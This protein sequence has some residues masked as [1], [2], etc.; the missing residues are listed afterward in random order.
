[1]AAL[2]ADRARSYL[3][4]VLVLVATW[5]IIASTTDTFRGEASVFSVLEGFPL[6]GLVALGLAI[7][8]IAG[9]LDL[10]V[11]SMAALA[12]VVAV[13]TSSV[14]LVGALVIATA[15]GAAIG[16]LQGG[17]IARLGINSLVLTVGTLILL[18]GVTYLAS[19]NRPSQL[20]DFTVSDPL[21][22]RYGIFSASSITALVVFG[23]LGLF[24]AYT[25]Y[26]REIY[27]IGGARDEARAAGVPR[28]RPMVVT[29]ALSGAC[30]ALAGGLASLKGGSAAPQNYADLLLA[31][32]AAALLGG[33]SLYGGRG[34]VL[35]VALGV[36][37]LSAVSAG[38]AARGSDASVTQLVTGALLISVVAIEFTATR[39][40]R[41][42]KL[43][44]EAAEREALPPPVPT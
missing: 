15:M 43:R 4:P 39:L 37:V 17:I 31:G 19:D 1:M 30:A 12:G 8:I 32:A 18:R 10:S 21:L 16:A 34:T 6:L 22:E 26:G 13:K 20:T 36:A 2:I 11:G 42:A 5:V 35:N 14:G 23:V 44:R 33:I 24:L 40:G 25:R 28:L 38:L 3:L 9:E 29:F 27:A 41:R 7:T